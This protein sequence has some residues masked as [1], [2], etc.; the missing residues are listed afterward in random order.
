M[1]DF[2]EYLR[3]AWTKVTPSYKIVPKLIKLMLYVIL[4]IAV[5]LLIG[6][7]L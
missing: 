7:A 5:L 2:K 6:N 3:A 1:T 4:V